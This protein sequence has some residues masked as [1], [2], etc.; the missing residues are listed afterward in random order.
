MDFTNQ[1]FLH[2]FEKT[3][4]I[5]PM[6]FRCFLK[7]IDDNISQYIPFVVGELDEKEI[8]NFMKKLKWRI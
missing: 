4:L 5:F 3:M 6:F 7:R 2:P 8:G 1:S